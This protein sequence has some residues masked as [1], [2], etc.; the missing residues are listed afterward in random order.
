MAA[1][2]RVFNEQLKLLG[3]ETAYRVAADAAAARESGKTIYSFHIGDLNFPTPTCIKRALVDNL[4][5]TGYCPAAGIMPLRQAV[6]DEISASRGVKYTPANVSV[7][8]GGKAIIAK[9]LLGVMNKGDEV[10][11]PS[12]GYPIYE[13]QINFN[14]GV[15]KPY[16]YI[17]TKGKGFSMDMEH[18][19]SQITD[20]TKVLIY[21]NFQNP[22]GLCSSDEEMR[23]IAALCVKHDLWVLTDEPYFEVLFSDFRGR[24]RSIVSLPGMYERSVILYTFSK[25][26]A[27][28]GWRLGAA[29]GPTEIINVITKLNTNLEAC[30]THFVQYAGV[31]ALQHPESRQFTRDMM[32]ELERRRD[33][34]VPLVN[35]CRGFHCYSP[36]S[37]F[38]LFANCTDAM[39]L[40]GTDSL[41]E[42]RLL[43]L[44]ETGVSFCT[45]AH[46]GEK[47]H[48]LPF[49]RH[50]NYVRFA[51]SGI[52]CEQITAGI[53]G[54]Q[55][56][57][58]RV[59]AQQQQ[60]QRLPQAT[61][62]RLDGIS[63][64]V[65]MPSKL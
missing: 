46:F 21:N 26:F 11:Y 29:V 64:V 37:T 44:A 54:L 50:N 38:Y 30:T 16:T 45:R 18:F 60:Q 59:Y 47:T 53:T 12:P 49:D 40:C 33:T 41:E 62:V 8:P 65:A 32:V 42:F 25:S 48:T 34:L 35:A 55:R 17:E 5:K 43:V 51:F 63:A 22:M 28:T 7:Q 61:N 2:P 39:K 24:P 23:E 10:L 31:A 14:G 1:Q 15:A 13:S 4:D 58:E 57:L 9:F 56:F 3:S 36:Q 27:M 6:A 52:S 20:K 19:R